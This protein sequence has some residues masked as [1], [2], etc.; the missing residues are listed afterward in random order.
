MEDDGHHHQGGEGQAERGG[1]G[2]GLGPVG[3][4]TP[5]EAGGGGQQ[6]G[7]RQGPETR[8][9]EPPGVEGP[10]AFLDRRVVGRSEGGGRKRQQQHPPRRQAG[11]EEG[12]DVHEAGDAA[13]D[14]KG[15]IPPDRPDHIKHRDVGALLGAAA[16]HGGN[17]QG[18]NQHQRRRRPVH[19]RGELGQLRPR[20]A[21]EHHQQ[22]ADQNQAAVG[23]SG[24]QGGRLAPHGGPHQTG[25]QVIGG[26]LG[27]GSAESV[28]QQ[29]RRGGA[30]P[31]VRQE[32]AVGEQSGHGQ[33]DERD[34]QQRRPRQQE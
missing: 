30:E 19:Q 14:V 11:L 21:A 7:A 28:D 25:G 4:R 6:R 5:Q 9:G 3:R 1:R 27:E 23:R 22:G 24:Q 13:G 29:R 34:R 31:A 2:G 15:R 26:R 20:G 10:A 33:L 32:G 16:D 12:A 8:P 18:G 17:Q